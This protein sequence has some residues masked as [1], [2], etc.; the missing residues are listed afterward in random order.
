LYFLRLKYEQG[1]C[2]HS[3]KITAKTKSIYLNR[4]PSRP[5]L[6]LNQN[7]TTKT[8]SIYL[9]RETSRLFLSLNQNYTT[10]TKSIYLNRETSLLF[11]SLNQNYTAKT[12][13]IYLNRETS[14]LIIY[15]KKLK[16]IFILYNKK[17]ISGYACVYT[18]ER[19]RNSH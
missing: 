19:V 8:K 18:F 13:S 2:V 6:S 9:N 14:R 1:V 12:K 3:K 7:Y 10:K 15:K 4:E 5:F 17:Y 16:Y 11:L